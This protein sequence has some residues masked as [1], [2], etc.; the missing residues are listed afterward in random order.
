[1]KRVVLL[2]SIAAFEVDED[3]E[4]LPGPVFVH[5]TVDGNAG[6]LSLPS[7][8][9]KGETL[10]E[11]GEALRRAVDR[12]VAEFKPKPKCGN[13]GT[14]WGRTDCEYDENGR[15]IHCGEEIPY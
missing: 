11:K 12:V 4:V 2:A 10:Q 13:D 7:W 14:K 5:R 1:M 3:S 6:W 9:L 15:C 8:Q